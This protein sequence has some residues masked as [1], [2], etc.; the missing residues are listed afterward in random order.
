MQRGQRL[1]V[2]GDRQHRIAAVHDH[3]DRRAAGPAVDRPA[4]QLLGTRLEPGLLEDVLEQHALPQRI[5]DEIPADLVRH[6]RQRD[7]ALDLRPRE[8][9]VEGE[10]HR[11]VD[12]SVDLQTPRVLRH[13]RHDERR[14]DAVEAVVRASTNGV[15]PSIAELGI[16]RKRGRRRSG[17]GRS[18]AA[19][20]P[21]TSNRFCSS[22]P[23][24]PA[25]TASDPTPIAPIM[26]RRRSIGSTVGSPVGIDTGAE[27]AVG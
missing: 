1:A 4:G 26:K 23:R 17:A 8:Q 19:R 20:S 3:L 7:V 10:L 21:P 6:A 18:S 16:G 12:Q 27:R 13:L 24:P 25:I 11:V 5:A 15:M 14:V 22:R 9:I 2:H